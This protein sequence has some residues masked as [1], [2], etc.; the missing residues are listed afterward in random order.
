[1]PGAATAGAPGWLRPRFDLGLRALLPE[2]KRIGDRRGLSDDLF[3]GL[4]AGSL[5]LC[6][7]LFV[8]ADTGVEPVQV[9]V[10]TLVAG[11][12]GALLSGSRLSS[13]GPALAATVSLSLLAIGHGPLA[14]GMA[15]LIAGVLQLAAGVL[16][17]GRLAHLVPLGVA[18][19]FVI[20]LGGYLFLHALPHALA[21]STPADLSALQ[22]LDHVGTHLGT[23]SPIGVGLGLVTLAAGA[24]TLFGVPRWP[25]VLVVAAGSTA[26]VLVMGWELPTLAEGSALAFPRFGPPDL[27]RSELAAIFGLALTVALVSSLET[28]LSA[29]AARTLEPDHPSDPDQDLIA[30]GLACLVSAFVGGMPASASIARAWPLYAAKPVTRRAGLI[31]TLVSVTAGAV[32]LAFAGSVPLA[33]IGAAVLAVALPLLD[34]RPL[35]RLYRQAR[36]EAIS[37]ALTAISIVFLGLMQGVEVGLGL[38][39]L[40]AATNAA[41]ARSSLFLGKDGKSHQVS[42]SGPLTFFASVMLRDLEGRLEKLEVDGGLI[43]DLRS[44]AFLDGT[45]ARRLLDLVEAFTK[46]G[47]KVVLLG[48]SPIC[49]AVLTRTD[50][51]KVLEGCFAVSDRE[52][53]AIIGRAGA[54]QAQAHVLAGLERFRTEM[55]DHYTPLFDQLA[56]GQSPHTLLVTCV[57][58]RINPELLTGAHP[59][60]LFIVRCL[61]ALVAPIG[62]DN[63]PNE[64][65]AVEYAVGVLGVRNVVVC[66]HSKCGAIKALKTGH[67]PPELEALN[68]WMLK[69]EAASGDLHEHS[70]IDD[71]ARAAIARQLDNLRSIPQVAAREK[72][73][74]L[75]LRAW[76]YDVGQAEVFEWDPKRKTYGIAGLET[77]S[78]LRPPSLPPS[79]RTPPPEPA[80]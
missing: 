48:V 56:D 18:H 34:P 66:G 51:E 63:L 46:R 19:G 2:L 59:G 15:C 31:A 38:S 74:E 52:V 30:N 24:G 26:L 37:A 3:A 20:G 29:N 75:E 47:G 71:A 23:L 67:A 68:R 1:V 65:A 49:R 14:I 62:V 77:R 43:L 28:V 70:D 10:T 41:R 27:P 53:D 57:D 69:A 13:D 9:L 58:S 11:L 60:E 6:L 33:V 50:E 61:G 32:L 22:I 36:F 55:R 5:G 45:G 25:L 78:S 54:F 64:A 42:L 21:L 44:V 79:P 12:F 80:E 72:A 76:F 39:L 4:G 16:G 7:S 73:G 8:A 35:L 40:V 17:I